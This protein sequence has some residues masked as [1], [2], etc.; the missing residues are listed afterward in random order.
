MTVA[1]IL[2]VAW[3]FTGYLGIAIG[4]IAATKNVANI[5]GNPEYVEKWGEIALFLA[6]GPLSLAFGGWYALSVWNTSRKRRRRIRNLPDGPTGA[7]AILLGIKRP[8]LPL[9][10]QDT[11]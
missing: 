2:V 3:F 11:L 6:L 1:L 8:P 7:A 10:E 4:N 5:G 9:E